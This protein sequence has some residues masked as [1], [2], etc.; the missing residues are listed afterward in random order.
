MKIRSG[1]VSNSSS[2]SF[3]VV[4]TRIGSNKSLDTFIKRMFPEYKT[5]SIEFDEKLREDLYAGKYDVSII[6]DREALGIAEA[7][8][9]DSNN[10]IDFNWITES[11]Q[12]LLALGFLENEIKLIIGAFAS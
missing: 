5:G 12:K 11:K 2:S 6:G 7:I 8:D 1:F 9:E 3:I 4:G 10:E